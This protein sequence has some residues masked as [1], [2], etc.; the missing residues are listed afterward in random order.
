MAYQNLDIIW[1]T[2]EHRVDLVLE[3]AREQFVGFIQ[4]Q[5]FDFVHF[6]IYQ[7]VV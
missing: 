5:Y 7:I 6:L 2:F 1:Q 4:N 3:P